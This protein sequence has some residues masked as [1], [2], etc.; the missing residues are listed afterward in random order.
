MR[1]SEMKRLISV[2]LA[3]SI[4]LLKPEPKLVEAVDAGTEW[5]QLVAAAKKEGKVVI[6]A[7]PGAEFRTGVQAVLKKR[8]DL[9][10]EFI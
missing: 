4:F 8:V 7:P 5:Q 3:A 6:G 9:D 1:G 10:S 2:F